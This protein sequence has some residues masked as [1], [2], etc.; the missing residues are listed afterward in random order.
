MTF[1]FHT[2]DP[3]VLRVTL[4]NFAA[5]VTWSPELCTPGVI[6]IKIRQDFMKIYTQ[7]CARAHT[8]THGE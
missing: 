6:G 4:Q 3:K 7:A 2:K 1:K 8:L 5:W